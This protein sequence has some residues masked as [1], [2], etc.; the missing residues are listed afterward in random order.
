[1][2]FLPRLARVSALVAA[3]ALL[4][5]APS[6]DAQ[7]FRERLGTAMTGA[8]KAVTGATQQV[9]D[10]VTSTTDL[11]V[12]EPTPE[13]TRAKLDAMA[14]ETLARLFAEQPGTIALFDQ[15][16]GYAVF[17]TRKMVLFGLAAGAG[18]GVAIARSR[19][20]PVPV[21]DA[22][23][24]T[25]AD[26]DADVPDA[27][28]E[29]EAAQPENPMP[30]FEADPPLPAERRVYMNMG[31]AGVG[32]SLG[33]GGFQTQVVMLFQDEWRFNEFITNGYDATADAGTMFGSEKAGLD[34]SFVDGRAIFFLTEQGWKVSATAAGTK[35]WVDA[36]I[37]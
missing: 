31:T 15:S 17:D 29:F 8:G 12:N 23:A 32:F 35:Y 9:E 34:L 30:V 33:V 7:S 36:N 19:P 26:T 21:P 28:A 24:D 13:A 2:P 25:A 16:A 4:G 3:G 5:P 18:R 10:A 14:A 11:M 37:N 6:V 1:M 22:S 27:D 20:V